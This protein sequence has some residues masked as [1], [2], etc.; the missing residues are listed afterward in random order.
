MTLDY[1]ANDDPEA[2]IDG[3]FRYW[4][5]KRSPSALTPAGMG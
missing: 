4:K 5:G 3:T 1:Q 2:E